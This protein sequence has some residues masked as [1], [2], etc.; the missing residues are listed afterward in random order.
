M[1]RKQ[2]A[3]F[4]A[5]VCFGLVA[6]AGLSAD[7]TPRLTERVQFRRPVAA[8]CLDDGH[9]L[10]VANRDSGSLSLVDLQTNRVRDEV[11]VGQRLSGLAVL[12]DRKHLLA[13]DE[14]RHEVIALTFDGHSLTVRSR[15]TVGPYSVS[16]VVQPDGLR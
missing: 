16:V 8:V 15:L 12:P 9:T 3:G 14:Q 11:K 7:R 4:L 10:C 6:C 5:A 1:L 13:V 2:L